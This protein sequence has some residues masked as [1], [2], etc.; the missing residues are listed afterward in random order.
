MIEMLNIKLNYKSGIFILIFSI[1][2]D[3]YYILNKKQLMTQNYCFR[4]DHLL[5]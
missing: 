1:T 3:R 4:K 5:S 2:V